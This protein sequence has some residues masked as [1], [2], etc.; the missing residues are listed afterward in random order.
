MIARYTHNCKSIFTLLLNRVKMR[1]NG[2]FEIDT[3]DINDPLTV[4]LPPK[5]LH[6]KFYSPR[7]GQIMT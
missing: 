7:N 1:N 5:G 6:G 4:E 2:K 3:V